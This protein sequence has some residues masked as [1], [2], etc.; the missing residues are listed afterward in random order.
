MTMTLELWDHAKG[1]IQKEIGRNNFSNW[2]EP[3]DLQGIEA[4]IARFNAPTN[5]MA[6]WVTRNF[7]DVIIASLNEAGANITRLEF[8]TSPAQKAASPFKQ[9]HSMGDTA[10]RAASNGQRQS[11]AKSSA[12]TTAPLDGRFTFENFVVGKPNELA[13]AAAKRVAEGGPVTF[14]PLFL[15]GGVGMFSSLR[16]KKARKKSSSTRSTRW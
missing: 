7:T 13:H 6:N 12:L 2:I 1:H 14:N 8:E 3:L 11:S 9:A 16:A 10:P 4:S 15:Y 5:F